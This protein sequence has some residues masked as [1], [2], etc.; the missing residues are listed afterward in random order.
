M[1]EMMSDARSSAGS[2]GAARS[3]TVGGRRGAGVSPVPP[4]FTL[5]R[6]G[7]TLIELLVVIAI[8]A[9]LAAILFPVFAQAREKAR[10]TSCLSN[11]KQLGLAFEMYK[12]DYDGIYPINRARVATDPPTSDADETIAWPELLEPYIKNGR[13]VNDQGI[14]QHNQGVYHCPSDSGNVAES[15]AINGWFEYGMAEASVNLPTDTVLLTEKDG[16]IEEEHF[17]WWRAPWP[18]WPLVQ[19]TAITTYEPALN[20]ISATSPEADQSEGLK[21]QRHN[22][23]ANYLFTDGHA[24]WDHLSNVWGDAT[25]TNKFWPTR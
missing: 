3:R 9:T 12:Q 20:A 15:Y 21:T 16:G 22:G 17:M 1:F 13:V 11:M 10:Q 2:A 19:G 18:G 7:F 5:T 24:R 23:G 6:S 8:I 14:V 25:T 4:A